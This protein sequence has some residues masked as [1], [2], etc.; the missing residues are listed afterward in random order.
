[1]NP[2]GASQARNSRRFMIDGMR[3]A[4]SMHHL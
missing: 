2:A 1:V 4:A 3:S